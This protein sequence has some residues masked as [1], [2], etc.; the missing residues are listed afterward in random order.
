[1]ASMHCNYTVVQ[2]KLHSCIPTCIHAGMQAPQQTTAVKQLLSPLPLELSVGVHV[3]PSPVVKTYSV[4]PS[5]PSNST[6]RKLKVPTKPNEESQLEMAKQRSSPKTVVSSELTPTGLPTAIVLRERKSSLPIF[7]TRRTD[8]VFPSP[9]TDSGSP[10][11]FSHVPSRER[12]LSYHSEATA[13]SKKACADTTL[14][15]NNQVRKISLSRV[16]Q[17][18]PPRLSLPFFHDGSPIITTPEQ[19]GSVTLTPKRPSRGTSIPVSTRR[20]SLTMPY[21]EG[22]ST[23]IM[24]APKLAHYRS[25]PSMLHR[26]QSEATSETHSDA[27]STSCT[28]Q[29]HAGTHTIQD[30]SGRESDVVTAA[31]VQRSSERAA[32]TIDARENTFYLEDSSRAPTIEARKSTFHLEDSSRAAN[33]QSTSTATHTPPP[34]WMATPD[35]HQTPFTQTSLAKTPDNGDVYESPTNLERGLDMSS[36]SYVSSDVD[37]AS[38]YPQQ[39]SPASLSPEPLML[40]MIT[41]ELRQLRQCDSVDSLT[42]DDDRADTPSSCSSLEPMSKL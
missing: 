25:S 2:I 26:K 42:W 33:E 27:A 17:Q 37:V 1:M 40:S 32:P 12:R 39:G 16:Q 22:E 31:P 23:D 11:A 30:N 19:L 3:E 10:N 41:K 35:G 7:P 28:P 38:Q 15:I 9:P 29:V 4:D 14:A 21:L 13:R 20:K 6:D 18:R 36:S 5:T 24:T 8:L 34:L